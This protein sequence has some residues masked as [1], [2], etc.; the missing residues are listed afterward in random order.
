MNSIKI[1]NSA[2]NLFRGFGND[3]REKC[4]VT[5]VYALI[6]DWS[7]MYYIAGDTY[8]LQDLNMKEKKRI[9]IALFSNITLFP[10]Y[11]STAK[12]KSASKSCVS[13]KRAESLPREWTDQILQVWQQDYCQGKWPNLKQFFSFSPQQVTLKC[14]TTHCFVAEDVKLVGRICFN[15][16]S[17][18][19]LK[20]AVKCTTQNI[21]TPKWLGFPFWYQILWD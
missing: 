3:N 19:K 17:I 16:P 5:H 10:V 7:P 8:C 9:H 18:Q 13:S 15:I 12:H 11:F 1:T 4:L 20:R 14:R 21:K 6:H 2:T